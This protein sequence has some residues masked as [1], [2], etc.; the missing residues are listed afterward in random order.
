MIYLPM[1]RTEIRLKSYWL[2]MSLCIG[3]IL[4]YPLSLLFD[5]HWLMSLVVIALAVATPG[6]LKPQIATLPY[7]IHNACA[8]IFARYTKEC[9]LFAC[10]CIMSIATGKKMVALAS[11]SRLEHPSSWFPREEQDRA[12]G[13]VETIRMIVEIKPRGFVRHFVQWTIQSRNWWIVLLLPFLALL[14]IFENER[15]MHTVPENIYTLF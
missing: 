8:H 9:L 1:P 2:V 15:R 10:F 12:S 3:L 7:R 4:A 11:Q 5:I 14:S 13:N 6:V